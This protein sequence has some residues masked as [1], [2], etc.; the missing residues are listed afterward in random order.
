MKKKNLSIELLRFIFCMMIFF[1]HSGFFATEGMSYPFKNAGFFA[2]EFFFFLTGAFAM[3]HVFDG[4]PEKGCMIFS[5]DY[6][7]GK[8]RR[9]WP[10]AAVGIVLSYIWY[11]LQADP[12]LSI[13]DRLFGRWNII[14][15][16][17]FLPMSGVMS[18][19]L[20][21]YLNTPLWYLSVIL[22][23]LPLIIYLAIKAKDF[24]YAYICWIVPL[25]I[26]GFLI[27]RYGSIGNWGTYTGI[28]YSG[29]LRG[30]ADLMLGGFIYYMSTRL[31]ERGKAVKL[32]RTVLE[33]GLYLFGIYIFNAKV[34]GYTYE[35][36]I[37]CVAGA[38][39]LSLS[40]R[41]YTTSLRGRLFEHLGALSLPI[42][43]L[44]WP[45]YRFVSYFGTGLSYW[46]GVGISLGICIILSEIMLVLVKQWRKHSNG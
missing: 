4:M 31:K 20:T 29:L 36:G 9:V 22:V 7:F 23:A 5:M 16:L 12:G 28:A 40:S 6:T 25:L 35:F 39:I 19:E 32:L 14:Y 41:T 1:H 43:C 8:L 34:D 3:R 44:H 18:V 30:L 17:L 27:N 46:A 37:L 38:L 10:Y 15:E 42:Y 11:F 13:K 33:I 2:V 45:V 24:Y 26:H 21:A